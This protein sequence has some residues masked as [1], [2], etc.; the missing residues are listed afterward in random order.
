MTHA[1]AI[2]V[3][4]QTWKYKCCYSCHNMCL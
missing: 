3:A 2:G 4:M 1:A